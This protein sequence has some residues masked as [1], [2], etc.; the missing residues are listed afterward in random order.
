M[1]LI[2]T[3]HD[4]GKG[5]YAVSKHATATQARSIGR[6]MAEWL[7]KTNGAFPGQHKSAFAISHSQICG[8][9][10][11][12]K[13]F[14][15]VPEMVGGKRTG[16]INRVNY[17]FPSAVIYNFRILKSPEK[18]TI[19]FPVRIRKPGPSNGGK[20]EIEQRTERRSVD[21]KAWLE[22]A[23]MSF[24]D[25]NSRKME[26]YFRIKV[27][28]WYLRWGWMPWRRTEWVEGLKA[29]IFQHE[30]DHANAYPMYHRDKLKKAV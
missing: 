8:D 24:P 9:E 22:E 7:A 13:M 23:C 25:H 28:Y 12:L 27:R 30:N 14:V 5:I 15:V 6:E 3:H 10:N 29:H 17:Y 16:K 11:P 19:P 1:E 20:V 26:R 18:I 2:R 4:S 21:N